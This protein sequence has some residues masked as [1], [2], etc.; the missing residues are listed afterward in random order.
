[1]ATRISSEAPAVRLDATRDPAALDKPL[2]SVVTPLYNESAALAELLRRI[3]AATDDLGQRY[4][5]EFVFV[6]DGSQDDSLKIARELALSEPR[7]HIIQLRRN[8]GQTAALQAGLD[9][10]AGRIIVTLDAD[11][12]HF[13]EEIPAFLEKIEDGYDV[14]CGWRNQRQ[15][16]LL[17]RWP[18]RAANYLLR[19]VSGLSIHDIGTTYRAYRREIIADMRLLGE[20]HRYVPVYAKVVGARIGEIPIR[21]IERPFGTSNYGLART[22]NVLIDI[23]FIFFFVRYLD[24]PIRIFGKI[25]LLTFAL[26]ALIAAALFVLWI[27]TG[28]PVVREHSGWFTL[29]V[30]S[31]LASMQFFLAGILGEMLARIYFSSNR[32]TTYKVRNVWSSDAAG[33]SRGSSR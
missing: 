25:A 20:S 28:I 29:S 8:Y 4:D 2:V 5:F 12:Q 19:L 32:A 30:T 26:G 17:R 9:A 33:G 18:S 13:P 23:F 14:V 24:R 31:L 16:G 7:L 1:M 15:E 10:A 3:V 11:L 6:D 27:R 21:N 22:I